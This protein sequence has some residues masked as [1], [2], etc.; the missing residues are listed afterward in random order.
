MCFF[1][2]TVALFGGDVETNES[3]QLFEEPSIQIETQRSG[4]I[5]AI[6]GIGEV[7][8]EEP[9]D[10]SHLVFFKKNFK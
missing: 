2:K 7:S 6:S 10:S 8:L 9:Q 4:E 3:A 5:N 1:L